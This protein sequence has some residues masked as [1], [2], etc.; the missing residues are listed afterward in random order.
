MED[1]VARPHM[2]VAMVLQCE[3]RELVRVLI[4]TEHQGS[5]GAVDVSHAPDG[6]HERIFAEEP[7]PKCIDMTCGDG[8]RHSRPRTTVLPVVQVVLDS[9]MLITGKAAMIG[10]TMQ[11]GAAQTP[12][13][14]DELGR[15]IGLKALPF[16]ANAGH[17]EVLIHETSVPDATDTTLTAVSMRDANEDDVDD[18]DDQDDDDNDNDNVATAIR[19]S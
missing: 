19:W 14:V 16:G 7:L 8:S 10:L 13:E 6:P 2:I 12:L 4:V 17:G 15:R 3:G 1:D 18:D 11:T 5:G 9:A